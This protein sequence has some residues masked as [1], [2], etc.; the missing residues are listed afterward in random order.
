MMLKSDVQ[1]RCY[2]FSGSPI[3]PGN[4]VGY[5]F[6]IKSNSP[7]K[8]IT[9]H[10]DNST[11]VAPKSCPPAGSDEEVSSKS[12]IN[13]TKSSVKQSLTE[14]PRTVSS[15]ISPVKET[16]NLSNSSTKVAPKSCPPAGSDEG[17]Y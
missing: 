3:Y 5:V 2:P 13:N 8:E 10:S 16:T 1:K 7:V 11:K 9:N 15:S 17:D 4:E 14:Q 6:R 12:V